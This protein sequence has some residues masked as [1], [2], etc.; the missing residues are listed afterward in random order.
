[1]DTVEKSEVARDSG[2]ERGMNRWN[3]EDFRAAKLLWMRL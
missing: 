1:M 2:R 3:T